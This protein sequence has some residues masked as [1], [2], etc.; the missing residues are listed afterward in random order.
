[1]DGSSPPNRLKVAR[2]SHAADA[3]DGHGLEQLPGPDER[4]E[5]D[6][7]HRGQHA[8]EGPPGRLPGPLGGLTGGLADLGLVGDL[9]GLVLDRGR[10]IPQAIEPGLCLGLDLLGLVLAEAGPS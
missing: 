10:V 8:D 9:A 3:Q 6:G 2:V 5:D 4:A 7:G 1:M